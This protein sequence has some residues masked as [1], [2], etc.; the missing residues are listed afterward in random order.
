M[1]CTYRDRLEAPIVEQWIQINTCAS[2]GQIDSKRRLELGISLVS[3]IFEIRRIIDPDEPRADR[4]A[5]ED[6][7]LS[8][9]D[10]ERKEEGDKNYTQNKKNLSTHPFGIVKPSAHSPAP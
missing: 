8:S 7:I 3:A 4:V 1:Y 9:E 5:T 6:V 2:D 10:C